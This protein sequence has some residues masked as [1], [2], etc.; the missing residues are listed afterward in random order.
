MDK[1]GQA[2]SRLVPD[3]ELKIR[4]KGGGAVSKKKKV[5][6]RKQNV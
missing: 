2:G 5:N 1:A 3:P 6:S 4:S